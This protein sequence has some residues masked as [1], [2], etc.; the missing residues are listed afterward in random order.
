MKT[1]KHITLKHLLLDNRKFIGLK[2]NSDKVLNSMI[3]ELKDID[4]NGEFNMYCL[5]NNKDNLDEIFRLFR[6]VAWINTNYF[7]QKS[8]SKNLDEEFDVSWFRKREKPKDYS[9]FYNEKVISS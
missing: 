3:K 1:Y 8:N 6:G 4:W 2:F 9:M 7:F 5:P